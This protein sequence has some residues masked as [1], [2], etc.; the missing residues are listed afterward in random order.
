[1]RWVTYL[2]AALWRDTAITGDIWG[3]PHS[4]RL[5]CTNLHSGVA[6]PIRSTGISKTCSRWATRITRM[7][8]FILDRYSR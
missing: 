5:S 1:M 6:G 7:S 2:M 4:R 3:D 8:L